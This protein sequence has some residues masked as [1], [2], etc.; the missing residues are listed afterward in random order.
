MV[1]APKEE[2]N[3]T[4]LGPLGSQRLESSNVS[5]SSHPIEESM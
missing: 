3:G 2:R 5:M 1:P 4:Q